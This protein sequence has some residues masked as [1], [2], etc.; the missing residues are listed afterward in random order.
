MS[1][2]TKRKQMFLREEI[3]EKGYEAK[4]FTKYLNQVREEGIY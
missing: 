2:S 1:N 3:I 4:E